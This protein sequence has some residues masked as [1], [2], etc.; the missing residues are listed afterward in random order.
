MPPVDA[1][2]ERRRL[3][4]R[5]AVEADDDLLAVLDAPQPLA[6]GVDEC[7]L[8]VAHARDGAAVLGHDGHLGAGALQE[9]GHEAVHDLR[10]L[11]EVGVLE[12]VG[13]V[14]QDLLDAQRPLLVPRAGQAEGLVPGRELDRPRP[15]AAPQR[16]RQRLEDD[17]LDVVLRLGLREA[18]RVDLHAVAEAQVALVGDAVAL[19]AELLPQHRHGAELRVLLDEADT[20]VDEER[21]AAEDR[22]H[23]LLRHPL[24]H[25]VEDRDGV[26][27]GVGDLLDR[28]RARLLQVVAADVDRVPPRHVL[29]GVGHHVGDQPHRRPGREG[30]GPAGE[31]LLDDVVLGRALEDALVDPVVLGRDDVEGQQPGGRRVDRH[32]RVHRVE[33]DAVEQR[34]HVALVGHGDAD[35][36]DLAARQDVVGVVAGLRR[37][38]EGDREAGL[39]LGEVAAVELVGLRG[40]R[41]AG[42]GPHHPRTVA[43]GQAVLGG[44]HGVPG[45]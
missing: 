25:R 22:A 18:E 26:R 5:E 1:L 28:R 40:R 17:S 45:S 31:E 23:A 8:H 20:R 19:A 32:R 10:A 14:G 36:A 16:H 42:V 29:D 38:V 4:L 33:R 11:E 7:A 39:P 12:Q 9:L 13:L 2:H 34:V 37:Q 15:R 24:A 27:H 35:L 6:V 41:V 3:G 44:A 21:D 43:L 30:V